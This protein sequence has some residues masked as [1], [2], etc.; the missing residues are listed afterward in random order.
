MQH[1]PFQHLQLA[2]P[3][4]FGYNHPR[5][6]ETRPFRTDP[7]RTILKGGRQDVFLLLWQ[8]LQQYLQLH[9]ADSQPVLRLRLLI[10]HPFSPASAG[11]FSFGNL[12]NILMEP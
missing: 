11:L 1:S 3:V 9:L 6:R 8:V 5:P 4:P 10:T 2:K 12:R 7:G